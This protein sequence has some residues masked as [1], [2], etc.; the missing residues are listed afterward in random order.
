MQTELTELI[1]KADMYERL[2]ELYPRKTSY[3][4]RYAELLIRLGRN[5]HAQTVLTQL[6]GI[7]QELGDKQQAKEV[8]NLLSSLTKN[9]LSS[10]S[11]LAS[12]FQHAE[13]ALL[14]KLIDR[15]T[16]IELKQGEYL[17]RQGEKSRAMYIV[18][19]GKLSVWRHIPRDKEP[20]LLE[21]L[22]KGDT[23]GE[24][25]FVHGGDRIA[26]VLA[27][28]D[29]VLLKLTSSEIMKQMLED[30]AFE[31]A[32][33][34]EA[35]TRYHMALITQNQEFRTLP[36]HL[37][38]FIA[39]GAKLKKYGALKRIA[40]AGKKIAAIGVVT[41]G[42][43]SIALDRPDGRSKIRQALSPGDMFGESAA[44]A[45]MP[46]AGSLT[47]LCDYAAIHPC[48]VL[49]IPLGLVRTAIKLH[50]PFKLA[51]GKHAT[52]HMNETIKL[53]REM[54]EQ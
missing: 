20:I 16:R 2:C 51:L 44:V 12:F 5:F 10:H 21:N 35:T 19:D 3:L 9:A 40:S 26:D 24:I 30:S 53:I 6:Q 49:Y 8:D 41:E 34:N 28:Q 29:S 47:Y 15:H 46:S 37:R 33:H 31:T 4:Q 17:I 18:L 42:K 39:E 48:E 54:S 11:Y 23:I 1:K 7:L 52:Q 27:N 50:P 32:L 45:D 13:P 43:V 25:G 14:D 36:M 22:E 38:R